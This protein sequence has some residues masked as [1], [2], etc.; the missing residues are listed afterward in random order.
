MIFGVEKKPF[1]LKST[2][3]RSISRT[4]LLDLSATSKQALE[5]LLVVCYVS[6]HDVHA[7]AQQPLEGF[8]IHD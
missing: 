4:L 5:L 1:L 6:L 8:H 7:G 2:A 3:P